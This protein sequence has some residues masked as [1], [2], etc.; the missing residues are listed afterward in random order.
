M[1]IIL[2]DCSSELIL[3]FHLAHIICNYGVD[4][5]F[6]R[7]GDSLQTIERVTGFDKGEG[8]PIAV[9]RI[10]SDVQGCLSVFKYM[11]GR[12]NIICLCFLAYDEVRSFIKY[13]DICF[14]CVGFD[15][16]LFILLFSEINDYLLWLLN[17]REFFDIL[18]AFIVVR[19]QEEVSRFLQLLEFGK[20]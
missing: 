19:Q 11:K 20:K 15:Q 9:F 6:A 17:I 8:H 1:R 13:I 16:C 10:R 7:D 5:M 18:N 3:I 4:E 12:S 14:E 2:T